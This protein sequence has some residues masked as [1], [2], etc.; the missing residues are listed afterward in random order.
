M[1]ADDALRRGLARLQ[2]AEFLYEARLFPDSEYTFKH[3]LTHEVAYGSILHE[4]RRA[5]HAHVVDVIERL[6]EERRAEH[7]EALAH[8]AFRGEAWD[9]AVEYCREAAVRAITRSANREA[10]P[11]FEQAIAAVARLPETSATLEQAIDLRFDLRS[12]SGPLPRDRG[13]S[14]CCGRRSRSSS[15]S[16][17]RVAWDDSMRS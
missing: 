6:T 17:T 13:S 5:V 15:V 10:G 8:H 12:A 2:M 7:V 1:P 11:F 9:K 14:S 16:A 4:R 3:A